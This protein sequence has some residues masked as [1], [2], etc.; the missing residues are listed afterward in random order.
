MLEVNSPVYGKQAYTKHCNFANISFKYYFERKI[1]QNWQTFI[2]KQQDEC[3]LRARFVFHLM[4]G[5]FIKP[6]FDCSTE[7]AIV[8]GN[9]T[10]R[11]I[12]SKH[13]LSDC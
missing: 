6:G 8:S 4:L 1:L 2:F 7:E 11:M 13:K 9:Y 12:R 10:E 3:I 5:Y